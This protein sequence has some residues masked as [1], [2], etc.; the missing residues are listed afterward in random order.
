MD[1]SAR[2][3]AVM[4]GLPWFD[5]QPAMAQPARSGAAAA[6]AWEAPP[7]S[8]FKGVQWSLGMLGLIL[9]LF[10]VHQGV[11]PLGEA[12][13]VAAMVST[14]IMRDRMRLPFEW[15]IFCLFL[16]AGLISTFGAVFP[17]PALQNLIEYG[18]I[19]TI[20][21]LACNVV[22][23]PA[24]LRFFM[25]VWLLFYALFPMRGVLFNYVYGN[26]FNGRVAWNFQF[27]NPNDLAAFCLVPITM[28][29]GLLVTERKGFVWYGA[30][31]QLLVL[32]AIVF[33]TQSRGAIIALAVVIILVV[34]RQ[35]PKPKTLLLMTVACIV[36]GTSAPKNV[37]HR[38]GGLAGL[39][40][41]EGLEGVDEEG[42]AAQRVAIWKVAK[43]IIADYP[44][45][46]VG[47]GT[48]QLVHR[49]YARSGDMPGIARGG[50]DT[51]STYINAL[52]ETGV[53]GVS[54][55]LLL[56]GAVLWRSGKM[57]TT[58][59]AW[60]PPLAM[61]LSFIRF[62]FIGVLVSG[63]WGSYQRTS[64]LYLY[65]SIIYLFGEIY[66]KMAD[67]AMQS[68]ARRSAR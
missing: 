10:V 64:F 40:S 15:R 14:L 37:W 66:G 47:I 11:L 35:R 17:D 21:L 44:I 49:V 38:L 63:L 62:G 22:R 54:M 13:L 27:A 50:R 20:F 19:A 1:R 42:S 12:A 23:T 45:F 55:L 33:I 61:Q 6:F 34:I 60:S 3:S 32:I 59:K 24:Q 28:C 43:T 25:L 48:Y 41:S 68:G 57:V 65:I 16:L 29:A 58:L 52:A 4:G 53:L 5:P 36:V 8:P 46:G 7:T 26:T 9:Y 39:T 67:E 51:H 30:L 31:L 2:R 18:K 56:F